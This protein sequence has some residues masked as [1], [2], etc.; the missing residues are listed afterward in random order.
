MN[1]GFERVAAISDVGEGNML[2][3][4][5][6]DGTEVVL[7]C[8]NASIFAIQAICSHQQAWLD[9]GWVH[10]EA[11]EV[12]CPLH[13]GRFDVRTGE[14][15]RLPPIDPIKTYPVRMEGGEIFVAKGDAN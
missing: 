7:V 2:P 14:P 13:E 15:T 4:T 9:G 8:V 5:L 10:P 1:E 6:D 11:H 12:E 3:V